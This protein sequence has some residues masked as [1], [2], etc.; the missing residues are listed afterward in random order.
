[1]IRGVERVGRDDKA[2]IWF[3]REDCEG[4]LDCGSVVEFD[5][6]NRCARRGGSSLS[7]VQKGNIS[8]NALIVDYADMTDSRRNLLEQLQPFATDCGL[9][10]LE[11]ADVFTGTSQIR[12]V[13]AADRIRNLR[14]DNRDRTRSLFKRGQSW[15][16][17][18]IN[19]SR[20][21]DD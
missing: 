4:R 9:K 1:M 21:R 19:Q 13:S 15:I 12:N 5:C 11:A 7:G 10:I 18:D 14:K 3:L 6:G 17:P 16:R 20:R 2:A 8:G